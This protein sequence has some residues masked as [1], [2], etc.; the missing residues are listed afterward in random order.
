MYAINKHVI[1]YY[2]YICIY[3]AYLIIACHIN[4]R[5]VIKFH[6]I[7]V[8]YK[9]SLNFLQYILTFEAGKDLNEK[10]K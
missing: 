9:M 5:H 4:F 8:Q 1:N 7:M 3:K 6:F 10:W 2:L